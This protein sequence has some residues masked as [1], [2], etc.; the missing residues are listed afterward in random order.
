MRC[1][2]CFRGVDLSNRPWGC[3][4]VAVVQK[5]DDGRFD[6]R[7]CTRVII[8]NRIRGC[9]KRK[10]TGG[11]IGERRSEQPMGQRATADGEIDGTEGGTGAAGRKGMFG[12]IAAMRRRRQI[13][14]VNRQIWCVLPGIHND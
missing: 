2:R 14:A 13:L 12:Y 11:R 3:R 1:A 5:G 7:T 4:R 9:S 8:Q 6:C 10:K